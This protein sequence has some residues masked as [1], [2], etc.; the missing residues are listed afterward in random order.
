M[1]VRAAC[2]FA[3]PPAEAA[4]FMHHDHEHLTAPTAP[5]DQPDAPRKP[6][7]EQEDAIDE[8]MVKLEADHCIGQYVHALETVR[9]SDALTVWVDIACTSWRIIW[10]SIASK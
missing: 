5:A 6:K 9:T 4:L 2:E 1:V 8:E 10:R 3:A 7:Q